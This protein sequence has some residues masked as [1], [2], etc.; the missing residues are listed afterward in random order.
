MAR[1]PSLRELDPEAIARLKRNGRSIP[2]ARPSVMRKF[3]RR[4]RT[5]LLGREAP[6]NQN[7]RTQHPTQQAMAASIVLWATQGQLR[8]L[9]PRVR[10]PYMPGWPN[11]RKRGTGGNPRTDPSTITGNKS[12]V[13][14][15]QRNRAHAYVL[16]VNDRIYSDPWEAVDVYTRQCSIGVTANQL[17]VI[18]ARRKAAFSVSGPAWSPIRRLRRADR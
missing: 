10:T 7:C 6:V 15:N 5:A 4:G 2:D 11:K 16:S 1:F 17:A 12:E 18:Y 8:P 9:L 3:S 14:T 13:A